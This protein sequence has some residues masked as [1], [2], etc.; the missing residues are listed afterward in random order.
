M[1]KLARFSKSLMVFAYL[2]LKQLHA[3]SLMLLRS[4]SVKF[5]LIL[6]SKYDSNIS[7]PQ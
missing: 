5:V 4:L 6:L 3:V 1:D 7:Y 2:L